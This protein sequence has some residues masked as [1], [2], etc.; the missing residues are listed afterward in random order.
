MERPRLYL[1][2]ASPRRRSLVERLRVSVTVG[3]APVDEPA[4]T[5]SY[6]GA[7]A[8][9]SE[10]LARHKALAAAASLVGGVNAPRLVLGAD[11]I[12]ILDGRVLG[13]PPDL[14]AAAQ[15]LRQLR[16]REH[17]VAT[18]VAVAAVP[19]GATSSEPPVKSSLVTTRVTMR[20]YSDAEIAAYLATGDSL[21]KAGGYAVQ[22]E[23]FQPVATVAGCFL[24]VIGLPLCATAALLAGH[25][26]VTTPD[27]QRPPA[28]QTSAPC[29][30]CTRCR[31]P[32]PASDPPVVEHDLH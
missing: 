16:G 26:I 32:L 21:D 13:K 8:G 23:G 25:G 30:W 2:S 14:V 15:M 7:V 10:Y 1:A 3:V 28:S 24:S 29:A 18:G 12:V 27:Q 17:T 11:T 9:L 31:E 19:T 5:A 22:H 6:V 4:L 20:A